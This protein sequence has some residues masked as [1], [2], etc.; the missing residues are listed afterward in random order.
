MVRIAVIASALSSK[1]TDSALCIPGVAT[2]AAA[3]TSSSGAVSSL[4]AGGGGGLGSV[5]K[6]VA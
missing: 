6:A 5:A 3:A 2:R 1:P 4:E